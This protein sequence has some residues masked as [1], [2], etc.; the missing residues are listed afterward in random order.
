MRDCFYF[1]NNKIK[2]SLAGSDVGKQSKQY[3][4]WLLTPEYDTTQ[5][6][7]DIA[8]TSTLTYPKLPNKH[9]ELYHFV[10]KVEN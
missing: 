4:D 5:L 8:D 3:N 9:I 2:F 6:F 7:K 10:N 1:V